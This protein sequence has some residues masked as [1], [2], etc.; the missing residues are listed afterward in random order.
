[1]KR[2]EMSYIDKLYIRSLESENKRLRDELADS[3]RVV[4]ALEAE[5]A[6]LR[7]GFDPK[8]RMPDENKIVWVSMY[9]PLLDE[10]VCIRAYWNGS[11]WCGVE[12]Q[13]YV[14]ER[15]AVT[16]WWPLP[17]GAAMS[18]FQVGDMVANIAYYD[19]KKYETGTKPSDLPDTRYGE[20]VGKRTQSFGNGS[21][22]PRYTVRYSD[23]K[24]EECDG[25]NFAKPELDG[26]A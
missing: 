23:G 12:N 14:W 22:Y 10:Y 11:L 6:E 20:I 15:K 24:L 13:Y 19:W 5:V 4:S 17:E 7:D 3:R 1:M 9:G 2:A 8:V 21:S 25:L 16:R 18:D 26:N